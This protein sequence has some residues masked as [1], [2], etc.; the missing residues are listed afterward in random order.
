MARR[1]S[2]IE[3]AKFDNEVLNIKPIFE[4]ENVKMTIYFKKLSL[5]FSPVYSINLNREMYQITVC[6]Q[7]R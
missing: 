4:T 7:F 3:D 6:N 1:R 2:L 5:N